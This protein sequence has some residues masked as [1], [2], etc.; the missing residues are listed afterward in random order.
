M[1]SMLA[2]SSGYPFLFRTTK[3]V[4]MGSNTGDMCPLSMAIRHNFTLNVGNISD[5]SR[6]SVENILKNAEAICEPK[7]IVFAEGV[8]CKLSSTRKTFNIQITQPLRNLS[9]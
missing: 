7:I 3:K 1:E 4:G 9:D 6:F 5:D 8:L 2:E